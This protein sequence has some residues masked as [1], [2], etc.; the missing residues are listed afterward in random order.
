[1]ATRV[2][3][4]EAAPTAWDADGRICGSVS[5]PLRAEAIDA[6]RRLAQT[7]P[8]DIHSIYR[9]PENDACDQAA[10]LIGHHFGLRVRSNEELQEPHL[11]LW[12]GLT[13][14]ELRQRFPSVF[15]QW[16]EQ[17]LTVTPPDGEPLRDAIDRIG[18]GLEKILKRNRDLTV[19]MVLRPM[20]LQIAAGILRR[21]SPQ[22]IAGHL[23]QRDAMITIDVEPRSFRAA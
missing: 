20:G 23:H 11:G 3:L 4:I 2:I 7:L 17:P 6:L 5:L 14:E 21:E 10:R 18:D 22:T 13:P 12:Q 1:M 9:P 15:P 19:A 8:D 16:E